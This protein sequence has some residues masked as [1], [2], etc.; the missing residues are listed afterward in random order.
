MVRPPQF[1][2]SL[3]DMGVEHSNAQTTK[4]VATA[5]Q[6]LQTPFTQ[7]ALSHYWDT[8]VATIDKKVYLKN[9]MV[10]CKPILQDNYYFEVCVHNP[11]QQDELTNNCI[12]IL[13]YL[14]TQLKNTRIQMRVRID[15]A[16]QKHLAYTSAEKYEH[17]LKI[18]PLLND[19]KQEFGL[20]LD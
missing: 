11:G 9:T 13:S 20:V 19:L 6:E 18:N 3:R 4:Q 1:G 16:N 10:N 2:T 12:D 5:Q 8:F 7:E 15:E 14:R 17:L